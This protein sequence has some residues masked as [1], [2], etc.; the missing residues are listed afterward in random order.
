MTHAI[1]AMAHTEKENLKL[2]SGQMHKIIIHLSSE[3]A[4]EQPQ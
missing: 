4:L 3:Q 2:P 1:V